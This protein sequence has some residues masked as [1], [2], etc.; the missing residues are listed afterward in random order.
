[1]GNSAVEVISRS[2]VGGASL[3]KDGFCSAVN[4]IRKKSQ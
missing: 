4:M 3:I 1:M 2:V